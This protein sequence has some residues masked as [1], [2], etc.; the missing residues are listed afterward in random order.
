MAADGADIEQWDRYWAYGGLHSFS[1]VADGNYR[2][3]I[4][5]FWREHFLGLA[6]GMHVV[7]IATG[8]GAV[9]VLALAAAD[10]AG[11]GVE[12]SGVDLANID[13]VSHVEDDALRASLRRIRFHPRT[14]LERLPFDD[15]SVDMVCSQYGLEYGDRPAAVHE[16]GRVCT[17]PAT[18]TLV[19]HHERSVPLQASAEEISYLDFVLDEAKLWLH[20]RNLLRAMAEQKGGTSAKVGRKQRALNEVLQRI[21]TKAREVRNPRMLLG[22]TNYIREILSMA[23]RTPYAKLLELLEET[24]QRVLANRQR[25]IDMQQ[26]AL[27]EP[28][29][30]ALEQLLEAEGFKA[31]ERGPLYEDDGGLLGWKLHARRE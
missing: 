10:E 30:H 8:N 1:Q 28:D 7:D 3:A 19:L 4:A 15:S 21:Q 6:D 18:V 29:L 12:I 24:R 22:P 23:G 17:K 5:D 9:A 26:A 14:P 16:I 13:P 31:V 20:A 2:G 27:S 25:L 11:V